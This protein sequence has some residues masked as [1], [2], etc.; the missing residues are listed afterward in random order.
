MI[1][2]YLQRMRIKMNLIQRMTPRPKP[3]IQWICV[4]RFHHHHHHKNYA[5]STT[6]MLIY[7]RK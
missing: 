5:K 6:Q 4:G 7:T 3:K 2:I 1:V